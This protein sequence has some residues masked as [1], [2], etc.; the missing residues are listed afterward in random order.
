[1]VVGGPKC[2]VPKHVYMQIVVWLQEDWIMSLGDFDAMPERF[3]TKSCTVLLCF[4]ELFT[5]NTG[6][7]VLFY[8]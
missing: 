5:H 2:Q 1:M 6:G 8:C 3:G 4:I 7:N